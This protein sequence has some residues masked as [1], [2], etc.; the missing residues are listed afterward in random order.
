MLSHR[1]AIVTA[2]ATFALILV[3]GLVTNTGS[4]LA[5][6]DWPTTFGY[7]MFLYPWSQ[8]VGGILYEHSHRLLGSLVG[9]LTVALATVLL[10]TERRGWVRALGA[11]AVALVVAQGV[12]GG[13]RVVLV[14]D[15]LAIVHGALAQAFFA[16]TVVIAVVTSR[17]WREPQPVADTGRLRGLAIG[18]VALLYLQIVFGA[19][20]THAGRVDLH[21]AGAA[22][23]FVFVPMVTARA[24]P[25]GRRAIT[26]P[27]LALLVLLFVQLG[28]GAGAYL[29]R[30][31]TIALPGGQATALALPVAPRL[32]AALILGAA[33]TLVA[34]LVRAGPV[35]VPTAGADPVRREAPYQPRTVEGTP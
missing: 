26:R 3:G 16:L 24:R 6:P 8:M 17:R 34:W 11:A 10:F 12:L 29:A 25:A 35:A 32:V 33:A 20:L 28:L 19:L 4:A 23:V 27:A 2:G 18:A 7:N 30:F 1:L 9:L 5:V 21:L 15:T 13:L 14:K 31:S 22:A